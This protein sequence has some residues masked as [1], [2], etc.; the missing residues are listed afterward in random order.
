MLQSNYGFIGPPHSSSC[1]LNG[2]LKIVNCILIL[3]WCWSVLDL[4][5]VQTK[6]FEMK[7]INWCARL[8]LGS[9]PLYESSW[10]PVL[11]WSKPVWPVPRVHLQMDQQCTVGKFWGSHGHFYGHNSS[12]FKEKGPVMNDGAG[13]DVFL[14]AARPTVWHDKWLMNDY[15]PTTI[16][17]GLRPIRCWEPRC[18]NLFYIKPKQ[19]IADQLCDDAEMNG[20]VANIVCNTGGLMIL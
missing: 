8:V 14:P 16:R 6:Q 17:R 19:T 5:K 3:I 10:W 11:S 15:S 1:I 12:E 2:G 4:F 9:E 7:L 18:Q 13:S 20:S